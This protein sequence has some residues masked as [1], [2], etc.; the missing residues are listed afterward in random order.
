[1]HLPC[2]GNGL[3][4][5]GID[6]GIRNNLPQEIQTPFANA[7]GILF[8]S[9]HCKARH[10]GIIGGGANGDGL[11]EPGGPCEGA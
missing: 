8:V 1:M 6:G 7:L 5:I 3:N 4:I 11:F 10:I 9:P 2:D